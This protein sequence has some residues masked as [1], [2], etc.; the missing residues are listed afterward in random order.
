MIAQIS[1]FIKNINKLNKENHKGKVIDGKKIYTC[2][3]LKLISKFN[4]NLSN[5]YAHAIKA[6]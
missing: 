2:N 5:A 3:P 6:L 4:K 1:S